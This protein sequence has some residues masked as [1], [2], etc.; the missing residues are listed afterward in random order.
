MHRPMIVTIGCSASTARGTSR[1]CSNSTAVA[2]I[3]PAPRQASVRRL[4]SAK[5]EKRHMP[6]GTRARVSTAR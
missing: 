1:N 5:P 3:A 6:R 2:A 4:T